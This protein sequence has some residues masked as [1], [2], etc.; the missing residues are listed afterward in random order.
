MKNK[1]A[2][3]IKTAL[4]CIL[5]VAL[6]CLCA[7]YLFGFEKTSSPEF[8]TEELYALRVRSAKY[9]YA[10]EFSHS[11]VSPLF[12]V[13]SAGGT[14]RCVFAEDERSSVSSVYSDM[15]EYLPSLLGESA[16]CRLLE[17]GEGE[18]IVADILDGDYIF[19]RFGCDIP[20]SVLYY[21]TF[22]SNIDENVSDE[23]LRDIFIY[24]T[25]P[26]E[27]VEISGQDHR[28]VTDARAFSAIGVNSHGEYFMYS[29]G[30]SV[31]SSDDTYFSKS[32]LMSYN[33]T[34]AVSP[35]FAYET[36]NMR[37]SG[38]FEATQIVIPTCLLRCVGF[39]AREFSGDTSIG[40]AVNAFTLNYEKAARYLG[41]DGSQM[42][43]EEG[44]NVLISGGGHLTYTATG[45][46]GATIEDIFYVGG[47][48]YSVCDYVGC[49]L[50]LLSR[51]GLE[52]GNAVPAIENIV[53]KDGRVVVSFGYRVGNVPVVRG[54][55]KEFIRFEYSAGKL[56]YASVE[57]LYAE[58]SGKYEYVFQKWDADVYILSSSSPCRLELAYCPDEASGGKTVCASWVAAVTAGGGK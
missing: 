51:I 25:G 16:S 39:S 20:R 29:P 5:L 24:P 37:S 36:E 4:V 8:T 38:L 11:L 27:T 40:R 58:N 31:R 32:E 1:T 41:E 44:Q 9:T 14:R 26:S 10:E 30:L 28:I 13:I 2:E 53:K 17:G 15:S 49:S 19:I 57:A 56:V 23:Y 55:K 18:K 50:M 43:I 21:I 35:E 34:G 52:T 33:M 6:I 54:G 48:D 3:L 22:P 12:T 45:S 46:G 7:V 47:E 42:F